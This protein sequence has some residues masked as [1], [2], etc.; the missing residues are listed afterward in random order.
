LSTDDTLTLAPDCLLVFIDDTGHEALSDDHS[1]Y[2]LGE[3][4]LLKDHYDQVINPAWLEVRRAINGNP[5]APLHGSS[6]GQRAKAEDFAVLRTFFQA[7]QFPRFAASVSRSTVLPTDLDAMIAV[8]ET[9]RTHASNL[10]TAIDCSSAA[11]IIESSQR[12]DP[13][14]RERF[15]GLEVQR[16]GRDISVEYFLCRSRPMSQD[17]RSRILPPVLLEAS[18]GGGSTKRKDSRPTSEMSLWG[19]CRK[20]LHISARLIA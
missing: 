8:A 5:A 2:G 15:L 17:W 16:D 13:L 1:Y 6:F 20:D 12:A 7:Y 3:V 19:T 4:A 18:Q 14:L 11:I 9:I 10:V